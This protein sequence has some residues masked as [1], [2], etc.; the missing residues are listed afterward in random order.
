MVLLGIL[1]RSGLID[2]D[3]GPSF[4]IPEPL[5]MGELLFSSFDLEAL[6]MASGGVASSLS[7]Q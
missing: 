1:E 2:N 6:G 3:Q 7:V 5:L 4:L